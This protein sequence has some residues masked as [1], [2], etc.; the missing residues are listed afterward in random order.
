M[1]VRSRPVWASGGLAESGKGTFTPGST[2]Q[3]G[4]CLEQLVAG[5]FHGNTSTD[6]VVA[7][8]Q[9]G[10][11]EDLAMHAANGDGTLQ[12]GQSIVGLIP[13]SH[14]SRPLAVGDFNGDGHLDVV[15]AGQGGYPGPGGFVNFSGLLMLPGNGNGSFGLPIVTLAARQAH[16]DSDVGWREHGRVQSDRQLQAFAS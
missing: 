4:P 3:A 16:G 10:A 6:D 1:R 12:S 5:R 2:G 14:S 9:G 11:I 8:E 13:P 7:L 15:Y